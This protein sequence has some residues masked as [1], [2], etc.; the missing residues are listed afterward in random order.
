M[1]SASPR[2]TFRDPDG[3]LT[4]HDDR[5]VRTINPAARISVLKFLESP[6]YHRLRQSGDIVD[7]VIED[8]PTGLQ[9]IHPK[10]PV[11]TYPWEWTPAQWLAAADLTLKICREALDEGWILKDATPLNILFIGP[12]PILVDVLSFDPHE[13]TSSIWLAY[14]QYIRTFLLP[15]LMNRMLSWPLALSLFRRDGYEPAELFAALSW[16]Q[17]LSRNAFVPITLP[18]WMERSRKPSAQPL[19]QRTPTAKDPDLAK[20]ILKR[21]LDGLQR[22]TERALPRATASNWASY[23]QT[24]THY[25]PAQLENKH[26][27]LKQVVHSFSPTCALDIG[28]NTGEYSTLLAELGVEVVA[29]E[30]DAASADHIFRTSQS[31]NLPIQTIHADLARPTPSVGWENSE[32]SALIPRLEAQFD[33]VMMLAVIHHLLL[34]EQIPLPA[35][36]D[37][38]HRLTRHH[39]IIEWVP[40]SDPMY[41]DLMRGREDLYGSLTEADLLRACNGSFETLQR[42]PLDNGR[43]LFLFEKRS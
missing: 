41:Q 10:V 16:P 5:A 23:Q 27:W 25:T 12:R 33:L 32:S 30:R 31:R 6:L 29:L 18:A 40:V 14:G 8:S 15:L 26:N 22:R 19:R 11:P 7:T 3:S 39:L 35:I 24:L 9:L 38:C 17:R 1:T 20:H 2:A 4:L 43:V 37:L 42:Q 28:A 13:P 36:I 34:L 21:M